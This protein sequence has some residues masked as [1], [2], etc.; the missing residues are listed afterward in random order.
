MSQ[1]RIM[2]NEPLVQAITF[3]LI[4]NGSIMARDIPFVNKATLSANGV[5][6]TGNLPTVDWVALNTEGTTITGA[7]TPYSES[8]YMIR[9][10]IDVDKRFV[11]DV[12]AIQDPRQQQLAAFA[13]SLAYDF[14]DKFINNTNTT[15]IDAIRG[16][17]Y[18]LDNPT[19]YGIPTANKIDV[20]GTTADM[21]P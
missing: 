14:N 7:P 15:E 1:Y 13:K 11:Q 18:R 9:N 2:S 19:L 3:S 6:W 12:N 20:G 16:I 10:Y 5:R 4:D 21:T 17:K 8:A